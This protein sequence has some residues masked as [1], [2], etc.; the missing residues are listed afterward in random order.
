M[1]H[2]L[3]FS[4]FILF[5]IFSSCG[6]YDRLEIERKAKRSADSLFRKERE[7]TVKLSDSLCDLH[8]EE[9]YTQ[10]RDSLFNLQLNQID[11]LIE[12]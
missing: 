9:Y 6:E 11:E 8:Y 4:F 10:S 1:N 3:I 7:H 12:K 5:A 2:K